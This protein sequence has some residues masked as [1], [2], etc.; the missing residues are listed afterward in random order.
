MGNKMSF[1]ST[2]DFSLET[3]IGNNDYELFYRFG[4]NGDIDTGST[5]EDIW[6][7]GGIYTGFPTSAAETFEIR[8]ASGNDTAAGTGAR[9][10]TIVEPQLAGVVYPDEVVTLN[11]TSWVTVSA[12][13]Y[14]RCS[15]MEVATAG[16]S[17]WNEG[18]LILRW[19]S[20]TS[21]KF[22][23]MP[24]TFA[25]TAIGCFTVPEDKT[26][27]MRFNAAMSRANGSPGSATISLRHRLNG[28][29]VWRALAPPEITQASNYKSPDDFWF[30]F[31][32]RTD[33]KIMCDDVSDN[34]SVLQ[35]DIF[36]YM[37]DE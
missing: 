23:D 12:Q 3:A 25:K 32:A 34:N 10:V 29:S 22:C 17:G 18:D 7:G 9:T 16:S 27:Y 11:G 13:V 4:R 19:T 2:T 20:T 15:H 6:H 30:T 24:A 31:P 1:I 33:I 36:G 28:G 8:S 35:A 37:V 26:L 5:P 21:A 14:D